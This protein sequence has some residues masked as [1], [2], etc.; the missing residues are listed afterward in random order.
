[1]LWMTHTRCAEVS[2]LVPSLVG[3]I[4]QISAA[5]YFRTLLTVAKREN[6]QTRASGVLMFRAFALLREVVLETLFFD[7]P[8]A[9]AS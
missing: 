9:F 8:R 7:P 3:Q 2:F 6:E 5:F 4:G 1:M